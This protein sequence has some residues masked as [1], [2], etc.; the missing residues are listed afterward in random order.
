MFYL[1][2]ASS[3]MIVYECFSTFISQSTLWRWVNN[4]ISMNQMGTLMQSRCV[5]GFSR[6]QWVSAELPRDCGLVMTSPC[7]TC[8]SMAPISMAEVT[9]EIHTAILSVFLGGTLGISVTYEGKYLSSDMQKIKKTNNKLF[10]KML[11]WL[12][13][14]LPRGVTTFLTKQY[15]CWV[16]YG[17]PFLVLVEPPKSWE[18]YT[19]PKVREICF[20][21][22]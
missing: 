4:I 6:P 1:G 13:S 7:L 16:G 18:F 15:A 10:I 12:P 5:S 3:S 14:R 20:P 22:P 21:S 2:L 9:P 17:M 8:C 19:F 11:A